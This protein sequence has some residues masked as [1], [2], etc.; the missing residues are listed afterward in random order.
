M[1]LQHQK[2]TYISTDQDILSKVAYHDYFFP[3]RKRKG[4]KRIEET[5]KM[6]LCFQVSGNIGSS[7]NLFPEWALLIFTSVAAS[8]KRIFVVIT[9]KKMT[10]SSMQYFGPNS[11]IQQHF[12]LF[13]TSA[14]LL[15]FPRKTFLN[16]LPAFSDSAGTEAS[17]FCSKQLQ[18]GKS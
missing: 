10:A 8:K 5:S 16:L 13:T 14:T 18:F 15:F 7:G 12:Q 9:R 1:Q 6:V 17:S 2:I 11:S 3:E 4:K